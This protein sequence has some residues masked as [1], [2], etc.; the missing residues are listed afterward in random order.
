MFLAIHVPMFG[1][2]NIESKPIN[3][4]YCSSGMNDW[5]DAPISTCSPG[6]RFTC[7]KCERDAIINWGL[8]EPDHL[9]TY[10]NSE[11]CSHPLCIAKYA[12]LLSLKG[13]NECM[14]KEHEATK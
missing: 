1:S 14:R 4:P 9:S 6:D 2:V 3:C 7:T 5:K 13:W 8:C 10:I 11:Y 12:E